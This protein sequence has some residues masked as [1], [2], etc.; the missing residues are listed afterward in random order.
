MLEHLV[1]SA[2][3]FIIDIISN[4][5]Y[6]GVLFLM[7]LDS[8]HIPM[9]SEVVMSFAGYLVSIGRFNFWWAVLAGTI[10]STIG[11]EISYWVGIKGGRPFVEKYGKFVLISR[12]DIIR[13]DK[14]FKR[15]GHS[16]ALFSR[17]IP[18]VR[19]FI[20]MPAGI[21]K[22]PFV[23]FTVYSFI[24]S[25]IWSWM[26]VYVGFYF[27][28]NYLTIK[29]KFRSIDAFIVALG[30]AAFIFWVIHFIK[31]E[32]EIKRE[33]KGLAPFQKSKI[34]KAPR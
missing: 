21:F 4:G 19:T 10:G 12:R 20:S 22:I 24:G 14:L 25:F 32:R 6:L 5:G 27:G 23:S 17:I 34:K 18:V 7:A 3:R 16:I 29:D 1:A 30:V 33:E 8:A 26:L 15:F 31:E 28:E 13:A 2:V 9:P 11:A